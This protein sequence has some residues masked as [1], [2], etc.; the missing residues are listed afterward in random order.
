MS[1]GEAWQHTQH[2]GNCTAHRPYSGSGPHDSSRQHD[3]SR[4]R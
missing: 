2:S 3:Q 1:C 4:L